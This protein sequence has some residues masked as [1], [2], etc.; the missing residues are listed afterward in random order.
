MQPL[1]PSSVPPDKA[2]ELQWHIPDK[3]EH[4]GKTL[5]LAG[6]AVGLHTHRVGRRTLPCLNQW[7]KLAWECPHC[8]RQKR[9][10]AWVPVLSLGNDMR[11]LVLM[12]AQTTWESVKDV[13]PFSFVEY[14][15]TKMLKPTMMFQASKLQVGLRTIQTATEELRH[16]QGDV[17]RWLLHYWQWPELTRRFGQC[18]RESVRTRMMREKAEV[19]GAAEAQPRPFSMLA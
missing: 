16:D 8:E 1:F 19:Y 5:L 17:T 13:K 9:F 6:P 12:G 7:P 10:T 4:V 14:H 11:R 3:N 15:F 2:P 18:F